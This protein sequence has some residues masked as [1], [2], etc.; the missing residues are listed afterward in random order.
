MKIK[1]ERVKEILDKFKSR[2]V[3]VIGDLMLDEFIWGKVGRISPEAP[4][5]VVEVVKEESYPGGAANVARNLRILGSH[6]DII[7]QVGKDAYANKLHELL[8]AEKIGVSGIITNPQ[9]RTI[10]K[11]R[12]V[13]RHQQ[14]VRVD[15]EHKERV[16]V[17][18]TDKAVAEIKLKLKDVDAVI[19]E[20][21]GKGFVTQAL[22]DRLCMLVTA[23]KKILTID[24]NPQNPLHWTE[25]TAVK[26]N[27]T[28]AFVAAGIAYAEPIEPVEKDETLGRVGKVL[29]EKWR[30]QQLLITLGEQG[31]GLF[32]KGKTM[33]HT[34]TRARE[35]FDV[36][37]AGDTVIATYTLA[38]AAGATP[39]EAAEIANHAA[40]VV[41]GKIGTAVVSTQEI[42]ESF[43]SYHG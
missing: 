26:P 38:L 40:G 18:I 37:G 5:P 6:V 10:V 39:I 23:Q 34:P 43:K 12:V 16:P 36:T 8:Q 11:T 24:P 1:P 33:Y 13:A 2:K 29:M 32:Q 19:V 9:S 25:P 35:V 42:I 31:M 28:E 15:R 4:V 21:Y 20:D 30:P 14:V 27:R 17:N 7:G 3:L 41:V 22:A